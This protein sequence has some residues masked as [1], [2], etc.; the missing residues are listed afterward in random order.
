MKNE[1]HRGCANYPG[2]VT[3]WDPKLERHRPPHDGEFASVSLDHGMV[4]L[5]AHE[6][7]ELEDTQ[8]DFVHLLCEANAAY[9]RG[10]TFPQ[11][12]LDAFKRI[13]ARRGNSGIPISH[14]ILKQSDDTGKL[15]SYVPSAVGTLMAAVEYVEKNGG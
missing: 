2:L 6:L 7:I 11:S 5:T 12:V 1:P 15:A 14:E 3:L 8:G 13:G 4:P 9:L 10:E